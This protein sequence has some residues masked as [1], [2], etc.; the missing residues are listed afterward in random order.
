MITTAHPDM[1]AFPAALTTWPKPRQTKMACAML[2]GVQ[3]PVR[4]THA[5]AS[6][7]DALPATVTAIWLRRSSADL[8]ATPNNSDCRWRFGYDGH[9]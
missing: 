1:A 6:T 5:V 4:D 7:S 8:V 3:L 9:D 2:S